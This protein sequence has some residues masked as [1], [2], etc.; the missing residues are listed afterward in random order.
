MDIDERL[1]LLSMRLTAEKFKRLATKRETLT[2]AELT[3]L[4]SVIDDWAM[5]M[6]AAGARRELGAT[7]KKGNYRG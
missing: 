5:T 7:L 2:P 6:V 4:A 1:T 3:T